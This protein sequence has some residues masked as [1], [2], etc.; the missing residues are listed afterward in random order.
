MTEQE[1]REHEKTNYYLVL[2]LDFR[3]PEVSKDVIK[4]VFESKCAEWSS[5]LN[6][7]QKRREA[8]SNQDLTSKSGSFERIMLAEDIGSQE[9]LEEAKAAQLISE[10]KLKELVNS[11]CGIKTVKVSDLKRYINN[12][13]KYMLT[14]DSVKE[15]MKLAGVTVE[16]DKGTSNT[17]NP[18]DEIVKDLDV[19]GK[20]TLYE[21]LYWAVADPKNSLKKPDGTKWKQEDI[22][23]LPINEISRISDA[24]YARYN[25]IAQKTERNN[26]IK[27]LA[28]S[29][30]KVLTDAAMRK[31][32]DAFISQTIPEVVS[33][34][35][36]LFGLDLSISLEEAKDLIEL[37]GNTDEGRNLRF[38]E[39]KEALKRE[40]LARKIV[41]YEFPN[42]TKEKP[43]F[44]RCRICG[45]LAEYGNTHCTNCGNAYVIK[46]FKCGNEIENGV[47]N[48][49]NCGVDLEGKSNAE[50]ECKSAQRCLDRFDFD[51]ALKCIQRA[52]RYWQECPQIPSLETEILERKKELEEKIVEI[53]TLINKKYYVAAKTKYSSL[54][55]RVRGYSDVALGKII[56]NAISEAKEWLD[57]AQKSQNNESQLIDYC[58]KALEICADLQ[59]A[60]ILMIKYP[61]KP[62]SNL[63]VVKRNSSNLIT[64]NKSPSNGNVT[65]RLVKREGS[66]PKSDVEDGKTISLIETSA[67]QFEDK[68]LSANVPTYYA[69]YTYRAGISTIPAFNNDAVYNFLDVENVSLEEGDSCISL[70]WDKADGID[71]V[72]IFR[73]Q[74]SA[75]TGYGDG[76]KIATTCSSLLSDVDLKNDQLYYYAIYAVYQT[77]RGTMHSSGIVMR[78]M[79]AQPPEKASNCCLT[80]NG[81]TYSFSWNPVKK[82]KVEVL[83]TNKEPSLMSGTVVSLAEIKRLFTQI[84]VES[85][86]TTS[87]QFKLT[88]EGVYYICPV[89]LINQM[90]VIGDYQRISSVADFTNLLTPRLSGNTVYLQFDWSCQA[91]AAVVLYKIDGY[92]NG[93]HDNFANKV[94]VTK[95]AYEKEK[96]IAIHDIT[97]DEYYFT[98]YASYGND[99]Y[100]SG[101]STTYNNGTLGLISYKIDIK[102]SLLRKIKG[103][104]VHV[105]AENLNV[106]PKMVLYKKVGV[107]PVN[108]GDGILVGTIESVSQKKYEISFPDTAINDRT[109]YQLFLDNDELYSKIQLKKRG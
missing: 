89:T 18:F 83:I 20:K 53:N 102:R 30:K 12:N 34:R 15:Q 4:K 11:F 91:E 76:S 93:P 43:A 101:V 80:K 19:I 46:C 54:T 86:T 39:I 64:W 50:A 58:S 70:M 27:K 75:I 100:S 36:D 38:S 26:A 98:I 8:Q 55:A 81:D 96:V 16:E 72:E 67:N 79:P 2:E 22:F 74:G 1:R 40:F 97:L 24:I 33:S 7:P 108:K 88:G 62:A 66:V 77:A 28:T 48:C 37:Y 99:V 106:I 35:I 17:R 68:S 85:K 52:R 107:Q 42:D 69:V 25:D 9:R 6:N 49:P 78:G 105:E 60:K 10:T 63:R 51:G 59:E 29:C 109:K 13:K 61:P 103:I 94:V 3:K 14:L 90:G 57:K 87:I 5:F 31:K 44:K 73:K 95:M 71:K 104:K 21:Y 82:G 84:S 47:N 92:P 23:V 56:D 41:N 65:Y 32:Y 45:F